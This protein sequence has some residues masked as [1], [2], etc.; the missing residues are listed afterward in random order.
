MTTSSPPNEITIDNDKVTITGNNAALV[1]I[2]SSDKMTTLEMTQ[3]MQ[4]GLANAMKALPNDGRPIVIS[5]GRS[6]A[7][8]QFITSAPK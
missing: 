8:Y 7:M 6:A 4:D 2:I 5:G 3:A 1:Q